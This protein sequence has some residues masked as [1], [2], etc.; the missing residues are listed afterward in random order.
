[1]PSVKRGRDETLSNSSPTQPKTRF[2]SLDIEELDLV[3]VN[4]N[5]A[6]RN[7]QS[8]TQAE[9]LKLQRQEE[10]DKPIKLS[11]F[12]CI[13]CLDNPTD[14]TVTFCGTVAKS[15]RNP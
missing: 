8:Q 10:A 14:L 6:Y 15:L 12:Q 3:H 13:I 11:A 7:Y 9:A 1:M 2:Q 5:E 4:D